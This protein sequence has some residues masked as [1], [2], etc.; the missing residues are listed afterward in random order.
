M[1]KNLRVVLAQLNFTVG[2]IEGNTKKILQAINHARTQDNAD[3]IVFPELAITGYPLDDLLY[4]SCIYQQTEQALKQIIQQADK[5]DILIGYPERT[6]NGDFN[7]AAWIRDKHIIKKYYKQKL[8]NYSVFDECRYFKLGEKPA[9]VELKGLKCGILICEDIW[10]PEPAIQAKEAGAQILFALNASPYSTH[11]TKLRHNLMKQRITETGV[12]LCFIN[13]VG[14]QDELVFD[15]DTCAMNSQY[16]I[17]A[18]TEYFKEQLLLIE[19]EPNGNI[20]KQPLPK[21]LTQLE[22]IYKTLILGT[23]DYIEK[24][25]FSGVMLGLSGGIDSALTLTLA[26]DALGA[27]R[28]TAVSLPSQYTAAIS[29][30]DAKLQAQMLGV[31][32]RTIP[33]QPIFAEFL[34]ALKE[35]FAG[36]KPDVTEENLQARIRG[37]LLMALS[38][39]FGNLVL[40]TSNKSETAVGYSTLYG[41]MAGGFNPLKDVY[42]T[43]VYQLANYRNQLSP[44]I[45]QRVLQRPPS[46]ELAPNQT[47]QDLLPPYDIL[48]KILE[49]FIDQDQEIAAIAAQDFDL[50]TVKK[51]ICMVLR[52]EYKRRQAAPGIRIT[53]KLFGRD[54]RYPITSKFLAKEIK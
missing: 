15:G 41:D 7:A 21:P 36:L 53:E 27:E 16:E 4:R 10:H 42:K 5:I 23:K 52:S 47:D 20:I 37:T 38:N 33:I 54:R 18:Q 30:E 46:A 2:D 49:L 13:L 31:K 35:S 32:Y 25:N 11:K 12:P 17:C 1:N 9:I 40:S 28:V 19:I 48:D 3:L 8:H 6:E 45:P 34:S 26:V 24:N 29:N 51:V 43:L 39:K 50:A 44:A 14:G 22:S